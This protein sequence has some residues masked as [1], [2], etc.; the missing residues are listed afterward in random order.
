[1]FQRP[2]VRGG[3]GDGGHRPADVI[4]APPLL[5]PRLSW[6]LHIWRPIG[7]LG[8][9]EGALEILPQPNLSHSAPYSQEKAR[10]TCSL[11]Q[12]SPS[13][14]SDR[15]SILSPFIS[16][17]LSNPFIFMTL[18]VVNGESWESDFRPQS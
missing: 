5:G 3:G 4:L 13:P 16:C 8:G 18:L 9:D 10:S 7:A 1:M 17:Q 14:S 2:P 12:G 6:L 15:F 11:F